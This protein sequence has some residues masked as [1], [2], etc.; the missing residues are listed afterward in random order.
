MNL[1]DKSL[2]FKQLKTYDILLYV[3]FGTAIFLRIFHFWE[4]SLTNDEISAL[5]RLNYDSFKDLISKGIMEDGHPAFVQLFLYAWTSVFG[6]TPFIVRLP[7][8]LASIGSCFYFFHLAKLAINKN[9]A[10]TALAFFSTSSFFITY[11]QIARPYSMGLFF[12]LGF[13]YYGLKIIQSRSTKK[14]YW[15][16]VIFGLLAVCSHYFASMQAVIIGCVYLIIAIKNNF[17]AYLK[18][19]LVIAV[20][21]LPHLPITLNHLSIGGVNWVPVPD[22]YFLDLFFNFAT[23]ESQLLYFSVLAVPFLTL[24]FKSFD[25]KNKWSYLLPF[26]FIIPYQIAFYYSQN[27]SPVLQFSTLI[28]SLPFLVAFF[29]SF[30]KKDASSYFVIGLAV[31]VFS[32]GLYALLDNGKIYERKFS[33][34]KSVT[35][36][37]ANWSALYSGDFLHF[38][39]SN[40]PKYLQF[41]LDE[42][43]ENLAF[44]IAQ[45]KSEL[46]LAKARDLIKKSKLPYSVLSFANV[47]LPLEVY[48]FAKSKYSAVKDEFR[49][50]NS[51]ALLLEKSSKGRDTLFS[52]SPLTYEDWDFNGVLKDSLEKNMHF[53]TA[54][55]AEYALTLETQ[56][57]KLSQGKKALTVTLELKHAIKND[58]IVLVASVE[59]N[60]GS[61]FWRGTNCKAYYVADDWYEVKY[62][63]EPNTDFKSTDRL[64]IYLW[65]QDRIMLEVKNFRLESFEDSDYNFYD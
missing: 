1:L 44:D 58:N 57:S 7:F 26:F 64:K 56:W 23:N 20:L 11:G 22:N 25:L 31:L 17:K 51:H 2:T 9:A 50:F 16:F 61:V 32:I 33:D 29:F 36:T 3:I 63:L 49:G 4:W 53:R 21:F 42:Q 48:E 18:S 12:I 39:N 28:F 5:S 37:V 41:Y 6:S 14:I 35:R 30:I 24:I 40:N 45:F 47:R 55:G 65:N 38:S 62:V 15:P 46:E 10:V 27:Y 60:E 34:F 43:E 54:E 19:S 13:A 59:N 52:I 8:V